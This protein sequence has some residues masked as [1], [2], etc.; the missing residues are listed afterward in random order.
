MGE[1]NNQTPNREA[2]L[3]SGRSALSCNHIGWNGRRPLTNTTRTSSTS[4]PATLVV[5]CCSMRASQPAPPCSRGQ[6]QVGHISRGQ[7]TARPTQLRGRRGGGFK[8]GT[9]ATWAACP[10]PAAPP[11]P[12]GEGTAPTPP[13]PRPLAPR[14]RPPRPRGSRA[15]GGTPTGASPAGGT[16]GAVGAIANSSGAGATSPDYYVS[17]E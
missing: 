8:P 7:R 17:P 4:T 13:R 14:P 3:Q 2:K 12:V 10:A 15:G 1:T 11:R 16:T 6:A 9:G 5:R